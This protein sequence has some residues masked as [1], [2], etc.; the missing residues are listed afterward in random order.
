MPRKK[1]SDLKATLS[2]LHDISMTTMPHSDW[3]IFR[4]ESGDILFSVKAGDIFD[5]DGMYFEE[6]LP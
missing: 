2:D 6:D 5:G 4:N 3:L 1:L